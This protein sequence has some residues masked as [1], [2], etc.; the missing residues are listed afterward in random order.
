[1]SSHHLQL[2]QIFQHN[3]GKQPRENTL[4]DIASNQVTRL[5]AEASLV[6]MCDHY[7]GKSCQATS[8]V[9]SDSH[10]NNVQVTRSLE[11]STDNF[12]N[13]I[14]ASATGTSDQPSTVQATR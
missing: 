10:T 13:L 8:Q 4:K 11:Q 6:M 7:T 12:I 14:S 3:D 1:M 2:L 9:T 5:V